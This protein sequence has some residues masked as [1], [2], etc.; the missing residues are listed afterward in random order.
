[1]IGKAVILVDTTPV[2]VKLSADD[3]G[4]VTLGVRINGSM[5][6]V[7]AEGVTMPEP[8]GSKTWSKNIGDLM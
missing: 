3:K 5:E 8:N 1:M 6:C 4:Q 2:E 7:L